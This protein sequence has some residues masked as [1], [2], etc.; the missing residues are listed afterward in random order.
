MAADYGVWEG[1]YL[2]RGKMWAGLTRDLPAVPPGSRVLELGCGSGKTLSSLVRQ[3]LEVIAVDLSPS[4]AS[5]S[6][7]IATAGPVPYIAA[8]D[9]THLPF[10]ERAFDAVFAV[11]VTGHLGIQ[12][13]ARCA[14]EIVRVLDD[15]GA[16]IFRG[17]STG[18]F[19]YGRGEEIEP[20]SFRRGAGIVTHY[21]E[22]SEAEALFRPL[23]CRAI[24]SS[25]W[26]LRVR[27][28]MYPREEITA[29]F[30][31]TVS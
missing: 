17:F 5:L 1:E 21:F 13:R 11:H 2:R 27:G 10:R 8:A 28:M 31:K 15:G 25:S 16:L 14:S 26:A 30:E 3:E 18:D 24:A 22:T 7:K 6:R 23:V 9:A 19:R 12:A 29:V 20:G 4:A